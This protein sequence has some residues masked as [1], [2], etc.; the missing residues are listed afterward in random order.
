MRRRNPWPEHCRIAGLPTPT[1]LKHL[2]DIC[3]YL[4]RSTALP[5]CSSQHQMR[6]VNKSRGKQDSTTCDRAFLCKKQT[7]TA[8][9]KS[10]CAA[11][12]Q[13]EEPSQGSFPTTLKMHL[14]A[15]IRSQD[16]RITADSS[17]GPEKGQD[18][19]LDEEKHDGV[20]EVSFH[21]QKNEKMVIKAISYCNSTEGRVT[22]V[23]THS[24]SSVVCGVKKQ[25]PF[26]DY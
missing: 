8:H 10:I 17:L 25:V 1:Q 19:E 2:T 5:G 11:L 21:F 24:F 7:S 14:S 9:F 6:H 18:G 13:K 23:E 22:T 4:F 20:G 3:S 16:G 15:S 26:R 12:K